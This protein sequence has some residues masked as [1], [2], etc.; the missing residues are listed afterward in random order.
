VL[1]LLVEVVADPRPV[2]QQVLDG[3]VA[4]DQWEIGAE[5]RPCR[6]G[7]IQQAVLDQG[8]DCECRQPLRPA[9]DPDRVG[10][11]RDPVAP[12]GQA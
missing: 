9:G 10:L 7:E 11:V 2:R 1:V 12:V 4:A 6:G 3:D 5:H 8:E